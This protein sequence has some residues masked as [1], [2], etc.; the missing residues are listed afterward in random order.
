MQVDSFVLLTP[1]LAAL[2][3]LPFV[4]IGCNEILGNE[5]AVYVPQPPLVYLSFK[6]ALRVENEP[7]APGS[8]PVNPRVIHGITVYWTL[9][10]LQPGPVVK[11]PT[12]SKGTPIEPLTTR[13]TDFVLNVNDWADLTQQAIMVG[14]RCDILLDQGQTVSTKEASIQYAKGTADRFRLLRVIQ[15]PGAGPQDAFVV[16][17]ETIN[18]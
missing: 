8:E 18:N 15:Q 14:C 16:I 7:P 3:L 2:L 12:E 4:F 11:P 1:L 5:R 9:R 6:R 17:P 10:Q 13:D